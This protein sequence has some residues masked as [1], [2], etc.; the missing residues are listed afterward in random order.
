MREFLLGLLLYLLLDRYRVSLSLV[1]QQGLGF[2][3]Q[4][5]FIFEVK[6]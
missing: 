6:E 4:T 5:T 2:D 1:K 3:H